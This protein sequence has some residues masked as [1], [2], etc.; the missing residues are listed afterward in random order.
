VTKK[1][2][3]DDKETLDGLERAGFKVDQGPN[4]AGLWMKYLTKAGGYCKV[5]VVLEFC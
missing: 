1:I 3:E 5:K 2:A 4:G